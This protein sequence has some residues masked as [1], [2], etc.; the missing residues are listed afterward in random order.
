METNVLMLQQI[1]S[2]A[3]RISIKTLWLPKIAKNAH[4]DIIQV[5][6]MNIVN[7]SLQ[8]M[9]AKIRVAYQFQV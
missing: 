9:N 3:Q 8:V 5:K 1:L 2:N 4:L 6:V 7:R